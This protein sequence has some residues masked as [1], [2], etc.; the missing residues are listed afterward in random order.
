M[1]I[2]RLNE[3]HYGGAFDIA[4]DQYFTREDIDRASEEVLNHI[5]ETFNDEYHIGGCWF[6]NSKFIVNIQD[7]NYN[8]YEA[9]VVV[10]MRKIKRPND[11]NKYALDVASK[12]I[13]Q[14]KDNAS[15]NES[16]TMYSISNREHEQEVDK[17]IKEYQ[18]QGWNPWDSKYSGSKYYVILARR[19]EDGKGEFKA[20]QYSN[21]LFPRVIDITYK[22][23]QGYD[24]IDDFDGLRR[25][26]GRKLLPRREGWKPELTDCPGCGD[27]SF[28][29]K[30][31][32]CT[33][34]NYRE[35]V[36]DK[37]MIEGTFTDKVAR[38]KKAFDF[39]VEGYKAGLKVGG[40]HNEEFLTWMS[41]L[42]LPLGDREQLRLLDE[43]N[44][45]W[46]KANLENWDE[47]KGEE[48]Y[49]VGS[50]KKIAVEPIKEAL[51]VR[52]DTDAL[53]K[54]LLE[55]NNVSMVDFD[56][57]NYP[58]TKQV[59]FLTKYNISA[60]DKQ[61][62]EKRRQIKR[63][64]MKV[65]KAHGLTW[66][67]DSIEDY[68]NWL[69]F[70]FDDTRVTEAW[71]YEPTYDKNDGWT[72]ADIE[73]HKTTDWKARNYEELPVPEDSFMHTAVAYTNDGV[74]RK[75]CK[76]VKYI[77]ANS[78]FPPYYRPETKPFENVVG[79]MHDG[80]DHNGYGIH[81][82]YESQEVY[83]S[84][85]ENKNNTPIR[86]GSEDRAVSEEFL[87]RACIMALE[88]LD[89]AE[90]PFPKH[91]YSEDS[92]KS[93]IEYIKM[94]CPGGFLFE[95][96]ECIR[97]IL[98]RTFAV[99]KELD[100]ERRFQ[101]E[102]DYL[103]T[104]MKKWLKYHPL[105]EAFVVTD[106]TTKKETKL[107]DTKDVGDVVIGITGK[108]DD[109]NT[110]SNK[111]ANMKFG[112]SHSDGKYS[113]KCV[114]ESLNESKQ[115]FVK[116][117]GDCRILYVG[118]T[119]V[120]TDSKGLNVGESPTMPGAEAIADEHSKKN[121]NED[122]DNEH[123]VY[124][125]WEVN[126]DITLEGEEVSFDDLSEV[127]QEHIAN[128][129]GEGYV[130]GEV[131]EYN[132]ET[133]EQISGWWS[134]DREISLDDR[135]IARWEDLDET[136]C[137]HIAEMIKDG[138]TSGELCTY[139]ES[140]DAPLTEA[141]IVKLS[142]D[143]LMNPNEV[144]FK[145]KIADATA[146][147]EAEKAR[148]ELE[149]RRAEMKAKYQ[150][151]LDKVSSMPKDEGY[152]Y[153][154]LEALFEALVPGQGK[155]DTIAGE[156]VRAVMRVIYR[157][158]NDGD[159][160]FMG[161]GLE[162]T[163]P[164]ISYLAFRYEDTIY[165]AQDMG[166]R[167]AGLYDMKQLDK[168]YEQFLRDLSEEAIE[169]ILAHPELLSEINEVD[170]RDYDAEWIEEEQPR[171]EYDFMLD[172]ELE[173]MLEADIISNRDIENYVEDA[174][175]WESTY[176]GCE[177]SFQG[178]DYVYISNLTYDGFTAIQDRF[179]GRGLDRF[180]EELVNE[181]ADELEEYKNQ[182]DEEYDDDFDDEDK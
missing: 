35:E 120:V 136:S 124:G 94:G 155:A 15:V 110:A 97:D 157:Y 5:S 61:Y 109:G 171:F 80:E 43:Y 23:A 93:W 50:G 126:F 52:F 138:Y 3:A 2:K 31:G 92:W 36:E 129:I 65:A 17:L 132:S 22:Q 140:D 57:D 75:S 13:A 45:G 152:N 29:S 84:L 66:S 64:V 166:E 88:A 106:N 116:N 27:T 90:V 72:D 46:M 153:N 41:S 78:I 154:R 53:E 21:Q 58:E 59:I 89:K 37:K 69:Y 1:K 125:W 54:D 175:C 170:S 163:A 121:V 16:F 12:I 180:W 128:L 146:E 117:H 161:Y 159:Y 10:D 25:E 148:Q 55:I 131:H 114:R 107:N 102:F 151:L 51:A 60:T 162:T 165:N 18:A 67:G 111:A 177:V 82:R 115:G 70:V 91:R 48:K 176:D 62:F 123:E 40:A 137:E 100:K 14:I 144:N 6:E 119:Y 156:I 34:C 32:K 145:K 68:G 181:H 150:G 49:S 8:E 178:G 74:R 127:S 104:M 149:A 182:E 26:L 86:E 4:D 135:G 24:P 33:K 30:K 38:F 7:N 47:E 11:L 83:D 174:F 141:P 139:V 71:S 113:I 79:P 134:I 173:E 179:S 108:E 85:F 101:E 95:D 56:M 42:N 98:E 147:E 96:A 142:D 164:S 99:D 44:K 9:E 143:D 167:Y 28:D 77:R 133:D 87:E 172:Y 73:L 20:I 130:S 103:M 112:D 39:G 76:F 118:S 160:F 168:E 158:Y 81:N 19:G 105:D 63:D 122:I 169:D